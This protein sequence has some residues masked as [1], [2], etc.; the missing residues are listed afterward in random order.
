[1]C[2]RLIKI[3]SE[4]ETILLWGIL[5]FSLVIRLGLILSV[6]EPIDRDA[7]EY[8]DIA[9]N[10]VAGNGFSIDGVEPTARRSPGYPF[11]L[12]I[13]IA[14]FGAVPHVLYVA[15]AIINILTIY[16]V[17]LTLKYTEVKRHYRLLAILIFSI[18]TSFVYINVLYAEILTMLVVAL[19]LFISLNPY[20]RSRNGVQTILIGFLIGTLLY[21]RPT[22]LYLPVF[23]LIGVV[24]LRIVSRMPIHSYLIAAGLAILMLAPWTIRNYIVFHKFIPLVLAGGSELW[25][26]NFEIADRVVWNSVS[27]IQKYEKQRTAS[28]ALQNQLINEYRQKYNLANPE[29]L[30]RFLSQQGR[31]II[32]AHPFRYALL[33]FNRLMIFW[34]SPPIGSATLKAISP[35]VFVIVLLLKYSLTILALFGL[36]KFARHDFQGALVWLMILLYLTFLHTATHSIQRYFLPVI[37]LVYFGLGYFLNTGICLKPRSSQSTRKNIKYE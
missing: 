8:I 13:L 10:L 14:V 29:D 26:A 7:K 12:A 27:D 33:S 21:L 6:T 25:G 3:A 36:Y 15:Q 11:F 22:F 23:L 16:L 2:K 31:S 37:P 18:S 9:Q 19:T 28:H 24:I 17:F 1:L 32:L 5:S 20:L 30:N 35:A 34:F 4:H